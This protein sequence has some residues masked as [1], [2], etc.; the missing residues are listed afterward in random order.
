MLLL[1]LL[2]DAG[3]DASLHGARGAG[4]RH[5]LQPRRLF[6]HRHVRLR[7]GALGAAVALPRSGIN[8]IDHSISNLKKKKNFVSFFLLLLLVF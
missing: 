8:T 3:G 2:M 5:Q 4:G 1:L 6:A 7:P